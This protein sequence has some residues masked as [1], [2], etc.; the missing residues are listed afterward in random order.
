MV[1]SLSRSPPIIYR[2]VSFTGGPVGNNGKKVLKLWYIRDHGLY[3]SPSGKTTPFPFTEKSGHLSS[4]T[5][6][7]TLNAEVLINTLS[8]TT[9]TP[10][11]VILH[12]C[13]NFSLP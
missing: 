13:L 2:P 7:A 8:S 9:A 4:T 6:S 12:Y 10:S 3:N 1:L 11:P 5:L